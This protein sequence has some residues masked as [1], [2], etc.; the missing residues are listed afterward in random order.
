MTFL[1]KYQTFIYGNSFSRV[2]TLT[3]SLAPSTQRT[4]VIAHPFPLT[5]TFRLLERH[6]ISTSFPFWSSIIRKQMIRISPKTKTTTRCFVEVSLVTSCNGPGWMRTRWTDS[7]VG[8]KEEARTFWIQISILWLIQLVEM[9][10]QEKHKPN[11]H[12]QLQ[13]KHWQRMCITAKKPVFLSDMNFDQTVTEDKSR[14][15]WH[16][17]QFNRFASRKKV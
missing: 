7:C 5:N 1:K 9:P 15:I 4:T 2:S 14:K 8:R 17:T 10:S 3:V 11:A 12:G 6:L 16:H 13:G